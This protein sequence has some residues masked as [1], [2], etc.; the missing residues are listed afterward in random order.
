MEKFLDSYDYPKL[1]QEDINHQNRLIAQN[2]IEATKE[3]LPK[4]KVQDLTDFQL[5]STR[6]SKEN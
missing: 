5:N 4:K 2:E 1:N 3:S 6:P